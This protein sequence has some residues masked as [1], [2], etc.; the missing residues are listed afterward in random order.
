MINILCSSIFLIYL[1]INIFM[2]VV[3]LNFKKL[4]IE[5]KINIC[6]L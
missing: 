3:V 6:I 1:E 4:I 2:Y 5:K